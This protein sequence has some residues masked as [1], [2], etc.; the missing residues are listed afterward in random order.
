MSSTARGGRQRP[1]TP[2]RVRN[3]IKVKRLPGSPMPWAASRWLETFDDI[4]PA[5]QRIE[6]VEYARAGQIVTFSI[7]P[8]STGAESRPQTAVRATVQGRAARPYATTIWLRAW[9]SEE[10]TRAIEAMAREAIYGAKLLAGEVPA[11]IDE[12]LAAI[13]P[14]LGPG[15]PSL[16]DAPDALSGGDT[17]KA[18]V[19]DRQAPGASPADEGSPSDQ[20]ATPTDTITVASEA[21][22]AR[23]HAAPEPIQVS[24]T[25][26]LPMPCKH[27][28]AVVCLLAERLAEQPLTAF[29]LRGVP[30]TIVLQRLQ[31]TRS[32]Q[33]H[34]RSSA[35]GASPLL[36]GTPSAPLESLQDDFWRPGTALYEFENEPP[37]DHVPHALLRRLGPSPLEGRFPLV[38]LL[39]SIYDEVQAAARRM[40]G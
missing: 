27:V 22:R 19:D 29:E 20:G 39:A 1:D 35:H 30:G 15:S 18:G 38:G 26:G 4:I 5:A 25:C 34:G 6:G 36:D 13:G 24:C 31:E 23:A 17:R 40:G 3:G 16:V 14:A 8:P 12:L 32:I 33:A 21:P 28:A 7:E 2:R 9:T 10:W 37:P 11:N